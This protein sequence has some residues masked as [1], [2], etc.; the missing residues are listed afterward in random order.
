MKQKTP[1]EKQQIVILGGGFAGIRAALD[2]HNYLHNDDRYEIVVVDRKDYQTYYAG[3]YEAATTEHGRVEARRVK[4][5]VTIP[6]TEIFNRTK[7]KVFKGFIERIDIID[8]KIIT[9]SRILSFDYL[10]IAMGSIADFYGIPNL[11]KFGYTLKSLEDAI[12]IRDRVEDLIVKQD[13]AQIVVGGGG[14]AGAE[15][16]GELH[17]LLKHEC[18]HH[19]KKL[20]NFKIMVVEGGTSFLPGLSEKVAQL[21]AV[22]LAHMK[23]ETRFSTLITEAARDYVT[24]NNKEKVNC[25]LLIWT[26]GI[27]SCRLPVAS[28]LERDKKDRTISTPNLNLRGF[29]NVFIAGDNVCFID[30]NTK[31]PVPQT[32]QEAIRQGKHVAKNIFRL[33]KKRPLHIYHAGPSRFVI[34]VT[35]KYAIFYTS[36]LIISG[37]AGWLIRKF[38]DLRYFI[39][40]LPWWTAFKYWLFENKI[41]MKND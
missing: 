14:F 22:R 3:L 31:K 19:N 5:T 30:L 17:N 36:N 34:P 8:G 4:Q 25:D 32:A 39:S 9:D 38:A 21:V 33:I 10:V 18:Q 12:M 16:V 24:L 13:S 7:V 41:F 35:G 1:E 23:I 11:D 26:G 15:F 29:Q 20:E 6:F 40:V 27:R 28:D 37:F 2:L